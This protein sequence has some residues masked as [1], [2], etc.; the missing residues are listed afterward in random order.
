MS[1]AYQ[2]IPGSKLELSRRERKK[3]ES[4]RAMLVAARRLFETKGY[5]ATSIDEITELAN[6]SRGTFFNYF[7]TKESILVKMFEEENQDIR[8]YLE[9]DLVNV[10]SPTEKIYRLMIFLIDDTIHFNKTCKILIEKVSIITPESVFYQVLVSLVEEA[11]S[12]GEISP[13]KKADNV[14]V[15][16]IGLYLTIVIYNSIWTGAKENTFQMLNILFFGIVGKQF[17]SGFLKGS[18]EK[19]HLKP[20]P[21]KKKPKPAGTK[22]KDF[23][24]ASPKK[25][26]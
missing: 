9:N 7:T 14:A 26:T 3:I 5:E 4:M 24:K 15:M 20:I 2:N 23:H 11:H 17:N 8:F 18:G 10:S 19:M 25:R 21:A 6:V 16:L 13:D 12:C 1:E 22:R